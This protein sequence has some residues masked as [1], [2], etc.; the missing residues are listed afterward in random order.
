MKVFAQL[1]GVEQGT[2]DLD[3]LFCLCST[4]NRGMGCKFTIEEFNDLITM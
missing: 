3:N 1:P 4:C 2:M